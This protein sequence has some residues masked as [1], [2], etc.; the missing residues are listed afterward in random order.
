MKPEAVSALAVAAMLIASP[1][2]TQTSTPSGT[3]LGT[4][5]QQQ[6]GG[7]A[8]AAPI[9]SD[10]EFVLAAADA[11]RFEVLQ[12]ELALSRTSDPKVKAFADMMVK[13]HSAAL[14]KLRAAA[15]KANVALPVDVSISQAHQSEIQALGKRSAAEFDE[16]YRKDQIEAHRNAFALV[17]SYRTQGSNPELRAWASEAAALV[18]KH[19]QHLEALRSL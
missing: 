16:A 12:G 4:P 8:K 17:D 11:N 9:A 15:R 10:R 3:N 18:T 19:Q 7:E 1:A 13:E 6:P 2:S 5:M 14:E